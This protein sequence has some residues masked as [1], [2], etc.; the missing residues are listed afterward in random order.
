MVLPTAKVASTVLNVS[1]TIVGLGEATITP[2]HNARG[3]QLT[4]AAP[5][6]LAL[7]IVVF[8]VSVI[9]DPGGAAVP[10]LIVPP[11]VADST[12]CPTASVV[13]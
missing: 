9:I 1:V 8:N 10:P 13:P 6:L 4:L 3:E 2:V 5:M 7:V 11:L 12:T